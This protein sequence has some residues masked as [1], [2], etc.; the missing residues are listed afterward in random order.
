MEQYEMIEVNEKG[1]EYTSGKYI[2]CWY[3][4][5][6]DIDVFLSDN[7]YGVDTITYLQIGENAYRLWFYCDGLIH[8]TKFVVMS[9]EDQKEMR[10][11]FKKA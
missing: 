6:H 7:V 9:E 11:R 8:M 4:S 1:R 3:M 2:Q 5:M 10:L